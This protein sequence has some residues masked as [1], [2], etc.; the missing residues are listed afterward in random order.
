MFPRNSSK[1]HDTVFDGIKHYEKIPKYD[2]LKVFEQAEANYL[3]SKYSTA[4]EQIT[5]LRSLLKATQYYSAVK[6]AFAENK[7]LGIEGKRSD[8]IEKSLRQNQTVNLSKN[9]VFADLAHVEKIMVRY[10]L[11]FD[12]AFDFWVMNNLMREKYVYRGNTGKKLFDMTDKIAIGDLIELGKKAF[13]TE[14]QVR[15]IY[16]TLTVKMAVSQAKDMIAKHKGNKNASP[17]Q[18]SDDLTR[19]D[20]TTQSRMRK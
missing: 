18:F 8:F 13:L 12:K 14:Q 11:D 9:Q 5:T 19:L 1:N 10:K 2:L 4:Q 16:P 6:I 3:A 15:D 20:Q 7:L 17:F